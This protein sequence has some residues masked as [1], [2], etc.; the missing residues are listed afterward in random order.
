M[1]IIEGVDGTGKST[2]ANKLAK[3]LNGMVLHAGYDRSWNIFNFHKSIISFSEKIYAIG[4][5]PIIDRLSVSEKVYGSVYRNGE[6]YDTKLFF[7]SLIKRH[8]PIL[9]YCRTENVVKNHKKN[10]KRR[11]EL[12]EDVNYVFIEYEKVINS[13]QYG[14]WTFFNYEKD[15]YEKLLNYVKS[16]IKN[17]EVFKNENTMAT[18]H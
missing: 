18:R 13:K 14:D 6:T 10:L 12:Y 7:E 11:K 5:M 17:R 15:S 4:C 9:I 8:E 16:K 1:I 2:L 3:D